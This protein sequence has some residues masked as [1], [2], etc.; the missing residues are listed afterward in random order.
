MTRDRAAEVVGEDL[1]Q[2]LDPEA[3]RRIAE[4]RRPMPCE[5]GTFFRRIVNEESE[6]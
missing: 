4:L 3:A 1:I 6:R 2:V 5:S